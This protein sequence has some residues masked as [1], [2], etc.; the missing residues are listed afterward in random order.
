MDKILQ[1][2]EESDDEMSDIDDPTYVNKT[3]IE[4]VVLFP[5]DDGK[6]R[7]EDSDVDDDCDLNHLSSKQLRSQAEIV[8][9]VEE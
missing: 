3:D 5:P 1:M 2:L 8:A 7:E 9:R 4:E 6:E